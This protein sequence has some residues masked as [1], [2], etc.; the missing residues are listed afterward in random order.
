MTRLG[1][2]SVLFIGIVFHL[3]YLWSIFDIYFI[4]PLVH[5]MQL[6]LSTES[7]PAQ[8]LFLMV[9]GDGLRADKCLEPWLRN[10]TTNE[11]EYAAPFLRSKILEEGTFGVSHTRMPTESRPG[12]VAI[13]AGFYEDVSAVTKGWKEN[14]VNFD[15]VFN[16]SRHTWSFGSPDILPMFA[17]GASDPNKVDMYS[18]GHEFE[19]FTKDT[20]D[21]DTFVFDHVERLFASA[22]EDPAVDAALRQDKIVFFL[23]LL[24]IDT[25]GHA[26]RPYSEQYFQNIKH[27]DQG[28]Q[29][30]QKLVE[31]FYQDDKTAFVFTADH[32]MSDWGSHGDGHPDNTRTPLIAWGAGVAKPDKINPTGHDE[33]S[34]PWG[35]NEVK[36][37]DVEQADIASLMTYLVG[38]DY[39]AN[40][41]GRLPLEF[42]DAPLSDKSGA[43][44][45][46]AREILEQYRIKEQQV[47]KAEVN[48]RPY[49]LIENATDSLDS[50]TAKMVGA[51]DQEDYETAISLSHELMRLGLLGL[52]YLQTYNWL[53]LRTL[54]TMGFLGW[55]LYA[56]TSFLDF[57]ILPKKI[58]AANGEILSFIAGSILAILFAVLYMQHA[59]A[60]HYLY[61]I[62]PI[63]FWETVLEY[64][65]SLWEGLRILI[66]NVKGKVHNTWPKLIV[67]FIAFL[68]LME[69]I[70]S[71]YFHREVF[72]GIYG[73]VSL[74]PLV[75]DYS[76][77]KKNKALVLSW[78]LTCWLMST[79]TLLPVVKIESIEQ[80]MVAG[81]MMVVM[82]IGSMIY[83]TRRSSKGVG[84][85]TS[86]FTLVVLG[87]QLGLLILSMA[88]TYSTIKVLQ[89]GTGLPYGNQLVGW[90]VLVG[91]IVVPF[92]HL[93]NKYH[94]YRT[95]LL[96]LFLAFAPTFVLL[97]ISY[98]GLFYVA[99]YTNLVC[100]VDLERKIYDERQARAKAAEKAAPVKTRKYD[101]VPNKENDNAVADGAER[102]LELADVRI[103]LFFFFLTQIAF[104]GTGNIASI[105]SF[106]LDS[107]YRLLPVFDPFLMGALLIFKILVPFAVIS[108]DLGLLTLRLGVKPSSLFTMVLSISDI[109]TLNFFYL[110]LDEGSWLDIGMSISHY[111]IAS[112]L[113]VFVI[114][115]EYFSEALVSGVTRET[116]HEHVE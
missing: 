66:W 26:S 8:R 6:F 44:V 15:S 59:P 94:D 9:A 99:F 116:E 97:T 21:L 80:I 103:A 58:P 85:E 79:F 37:V 82:G 43:I 16:Q 87:M 28:V 100:W 101:L 76:V 56:L 95:R 54:V 74:W 11:Y 81:V 27:V 65:R 57:Y 68:A 31:D 75:Q 20:R 89:N 40:S 107:V 61:A 46:N 3:V 29:K 70:V 34:I 104:F 7:P 23:H 50:L 42:V 10:S 78:F 112:L 22:A 41:V 115:L 108:A 55:I 36:R 12:H 102:R 38:L 64:R 24:G 19:D 39:P 49:A 53:F 5:G 14:P 52:R 114:A 84:Y 32:G 72:S 98:E 113:C 60:M 71:G 45:A 67:E 62:F 33:F 93:R 109:L 83:L 1:K 17:L 86:P 69:A 111:C 13:I 90:L 18:Y 91:S 110:V 96:V 51:Y 92:L 88:V 105:S 77:C 35:L 63:A 48:F 73:L 4:T 106:S 30:I 2:Q 47:Q 25:A